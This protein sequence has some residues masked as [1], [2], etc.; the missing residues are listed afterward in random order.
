MSFEQLEHQHLVIVNQVAVVND[1]LT[2]L[3]ETLVQIEKV[4]KANAAKAAKSV[5]GS[6]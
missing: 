6:K 4:M 1:Q 2:D 5:S 3:Q